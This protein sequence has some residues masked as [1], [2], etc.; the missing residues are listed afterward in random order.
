MT[1]KK[2]FHRGRLAVSIR[3][4]AVSIF[5]LKMETRLLSVTVL[6]TTDWLMITE[7]AFQ[8][9]GFRLHHDHQDVI[10]EIILSLYMFSIVFA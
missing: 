4:E 9:V 7:P 2:W 5:A 3:T 10:I 6:Q 1:L 8:K